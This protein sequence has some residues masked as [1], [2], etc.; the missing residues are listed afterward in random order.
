MSTITYVDDTTIILSS[1]KS[2]SFNSEA[3]HMLIKVSYWLDIN[4]L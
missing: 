4:Y 2:N 3:E 1:Y